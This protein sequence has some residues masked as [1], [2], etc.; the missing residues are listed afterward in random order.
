MDAKCC[1]RCGKFYLEYADMKR[2]NALIIIN[3]QTKDTYNEYI[4]RMDLCVECRD[5]VL[6]FLKRPIEKRD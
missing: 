2:G 1:D 3:Y 6:E 4:E 5:E